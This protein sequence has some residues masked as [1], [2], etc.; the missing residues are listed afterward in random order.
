MII[1]KVLVVDDDQ[2]VQ[3]LYKLILEGLPVQSVL[4]ANNGKEAKNVYV[5]SNHKPD[6]IIMDY[7]MPLMNGIEAMKEI[8]QT[9]KKAKIVFASADPS[10]KSQAISLGASAFLSKP[11]DIQDLLQIVKNLIK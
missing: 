3:N 5:N 2:Y 1:S 10:V 11:F 9:D 8:L 7:R 4:L 6:I